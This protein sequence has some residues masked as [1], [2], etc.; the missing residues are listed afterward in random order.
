[1]L[2]SPPPKG[3]FHPAS[4]TSTTLSARVA[5]DSLCARTSTSE[6]TIM[7]LSL[8]ALMKEMAHGLAD[9]SLSMHELLT[10]NEVASY[11]RISLRI[12]PRTLYRLMKAKKIPFKKIGGQ[13]RFHRTA[14]E[15]L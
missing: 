8:I 1:M 12:S 4:S 14:L 5:I 10:P 11:L 3:V 7:K 2:T 13:V 9:F 15:N 6:G